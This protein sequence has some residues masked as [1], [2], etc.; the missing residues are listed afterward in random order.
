M[1]NKHEF[2]QCRLQLNSLARGSNKLGSNTKSLPIIKSYSAKLT[3]SNQSSER[4]LKF[5]VSWA[6]M[7]DESNSIMECCSDAVKS[8]RGK[9]WA[10]YML[11]N[12]QPEPSS[13]TFR[14]SRVA[15]RCFARTIACILKSAYCVINTLRGFG[16]KSLL[17]WKLFELKVLLKLLLIWPLINLPHK[18]ME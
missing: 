9:W 18:L 8:V 11:V 1:H 4:Q 6:Q 3:S 17:D 2:F 14:A 16:I 15:L 12:P 10:R 7:F 5:G 13:S